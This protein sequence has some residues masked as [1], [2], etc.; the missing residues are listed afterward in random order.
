MNPREDEM[1][2]TLNI[3]PDL[4]E[5]LHRMAEERGLETS[6]IVLSI[7]NE[8]LEDGPGAGDSPPKNGAELVARWKELGVIGAWADRTDI[9][10]SVEYARE[11]R[12]RSEERQ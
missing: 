3:P 7:L 9:G 11:L 10:D 8:V 4:E 1:T 6:E 2:L 5:R 12:R